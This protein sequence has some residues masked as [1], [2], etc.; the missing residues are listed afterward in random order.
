MRT[1]EIIPLEPFLRETKQRDWEAALLWERF[2]GR[3][4][5]RAAEHWNLDGAS[6]RTIWD[7]AH[8]QSWD[9][10]AEH[11]GLDARA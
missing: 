9:E 2:E 11:F 4:A 8:L 7:L 10:I 5:A 6:A 3:I 1:A